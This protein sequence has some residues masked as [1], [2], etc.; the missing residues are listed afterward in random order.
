MGRWR[1]TGTLR[2]LST[3]ALLVTGN[4][5]AQ[6]ATDTGS[7]VL[8]LEHPQLSQRID[9]ANPDTFDFVRLT[10][11]QVNNPKHVGLIFGVEFIPDGGTRT[12]LGGFSLYPPDNP[13]VFIVSTHHLVK[14]AGL[15]VVTL[16]TATPVDSGT[17]LSVR[18]G[19]I[20]LAHGTN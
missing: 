19:A 3:W 1:V 18:M 13:G 2:L 5:T 10:V 20:G 4:S 6:S 11:A 15:V 14:S 9:D 7:R 12:N 16:H 17:P 8:D